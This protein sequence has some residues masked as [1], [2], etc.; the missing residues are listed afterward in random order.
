M[1]ILVLGMMLCSAC[2]ASAP[3]T[4]AIPWLL[5]FAPAASSDAISASVSQRLATWQDCDEP[6]PDLGGIEITADVA[7]AD[8]PETVLGS[9]TRGFV[10]LDHAGHVLARASGLAATG[11]ADEL[12]AISAGD[13]MLGTPVIAVSARV[14]GRRES[15]VWLEL[16]AVGGEQKLQRL[17]EA[18]VEEDEDQ[19]VR[20]G[21]V[22]LLPGS[23]LYLAPGAVTPE[24]WT[25]DREAGRYRRRTAPSRPSPTPPDP[26]VIVGARD[27][28]HPAARVPL[29][30]ARARSQ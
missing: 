13:A 10:V 23:L 14:G 29:A 11:S 19:A 25:F 18:V 5:G 15:S 28:N 9:Y 7:R 20:R 30:G 12:L 16:Y 4:P 24:L 17:F 21:S 27:R 6:C 2:T 3:S 26:D 22:I 8:G 1:R